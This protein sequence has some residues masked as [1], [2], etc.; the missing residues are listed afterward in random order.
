MRKLILLLNLCF[1]F[2]FNEIKMRRWNYSRL[3]N[4]LDR[5]YFITQTATTGKLIFSHLNNLIVYFLLL[6]I[7]N[8]QFFS[9]DDFYNAL[10]WFNK[11]I[12]E[13]EYNRDFSKNKNSWHT[14]H[15]F[16]KFFLLKNQEKLYAED[17]KN[18]QECHGFRSL[19][20]SW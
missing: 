4:A 15:Y 6:E 10:Q 1:A 17:L 16:L 3:F 20:K 7:F 19:A 11:N 13:N 5:K 12:L 2:I 8:D 18:C 14:W 9:S